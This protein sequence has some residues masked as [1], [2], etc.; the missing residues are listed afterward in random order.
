MRDI[1]KNLAAAVERGCGASV[2][3]FGDS[4][5]ESSA[6]DFAR[7]MGLSDISCLPAELESCPAKLRKFCESLC[8]PETWF[9]RQP[10]IFLPDMFQIPAAVF[11]FI[12]QNFSRRDNG[13]KQL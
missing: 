8:V 3:S 6:R 11:Q 12:M 13:I 7:G 5:V 9:F 4:F 10:V 1:V 2:E